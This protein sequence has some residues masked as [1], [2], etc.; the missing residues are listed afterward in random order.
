MTN[1]IPVYKLED[2]R[3]SFLITGYDEAQFQEKE[4]E[5]IEEYFPFEDTSTMT[6]I[7]IDGIHQLDIA[8]KIG[9]HFG[10]HPLVLASN[11]WLQTPFYW[12][13]LEDYTDKGRKQCMEL[14]VAMMS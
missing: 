1:E 11:N 6:W 8:E 10:I 7:N 2:A 14:L 3:W 12:I 13:V 5:T 9:R 4:L